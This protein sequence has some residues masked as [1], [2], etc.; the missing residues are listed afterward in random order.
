MFKRILYS[1]QKLDLFGYQI[2]FIKKKNRGFSAINRNSKESINKA[3]NKNTYYGFKRKVPFYKSI[4]GLTGI[5]LTGKGVLDVSCGTGVLCEEISASYKPHPFYACDFSESCVNVTKSLMIPNLLC[6]VHDIY[7]PIDR[8]FDV[9]YCI[10]T[11]E[12]L[13]YPQIAVKNIL[14]ALNRNGVAIITVPNGKLDTYEQHIHFWSI[15]SWKLFLS[16]SIDESVFTIETGFF[17]EHQ[18]HLYA[19][20]VRIE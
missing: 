14:D 17:H 9:V 7:D 19:R 8:K 1:R 5:D 12:H 13:L 16:S 6:S 20:I 2:V 11:I 10:E 18:M 3:V 15:D 4:I